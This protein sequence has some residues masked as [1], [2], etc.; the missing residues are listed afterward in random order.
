MLCV[1]VHGSIQ[2]VGLGTITVRIVADSES[3]LL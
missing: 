1:L 3:F 2:V